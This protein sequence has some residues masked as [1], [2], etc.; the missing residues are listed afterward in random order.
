[1]WW[2]YDIACRTYAW[3]RFE[4]YDNDYHTIRSDIDDATQ[5]V[6]AQ[7][8]MRAKKRK[9]N[10][11]YVLYLVVSSCFSL[12]FTWISYPILRRSFMKMD[13]SF[14]NR[15]TATYTAIEAERA[16]SEEMKTKIISISM[17]HL[18]RKFVEHWH[19]LVNVRIEFRIIA[20]LVIRKRFIVHIL[21]L[22]GCR[23]DLL[24]FTAQSTV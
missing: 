13:C 20:E 6:Y 11:Y 14:L 5:V 12:P 1:M 3:W 4:T 8:Y 16:S 2:R 7:S 24:L 18:I 15:D 17:S 23:R 19:H 9:D 10:L 21:S 22:P